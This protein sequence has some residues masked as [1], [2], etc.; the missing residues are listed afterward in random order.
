MEYG[1]FWG[2][3]KGSR[4]LTKSEILKDEVS[5][6]CEQEPQKAEQHEDQLNH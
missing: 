3:A 2:S 6:V 5:P 4:L 1:P